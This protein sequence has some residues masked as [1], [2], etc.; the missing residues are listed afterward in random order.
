VPEIIVESPG[1]PDAPSPGAEILSQIAIKSEDLIPDAQLRTEILS[2]IAI[3]SEDLLPK[4]PTA[5][6]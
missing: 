6:T 1:A 5:Q 2:Q 3:K 4:E